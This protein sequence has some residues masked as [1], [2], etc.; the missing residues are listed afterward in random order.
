MGQMYFGNL[1]RMQMVTAALSE[2]PVSSKGYSE[3]LNYANGGADV[4]SSFGSSRTFDMSWSGTP[5]EVNPFK[6]YQQGYY[7]PGLLYM[8]DPMTEHYNVCPPNWA[9]PRLIEVGD[10]KNIYDTTPTFAATSANSYNQPARK[11]TW[12]ITTAAAG[13]PAHVLTLPIPPDRVL[14]IGAS[15]AATGTA[16]VRVRP[17]NL[18]GTYAA[19]SDLTLLSDTGSARLNKT[20][21]GA[22]YKAVQVYFT[23][24]TSVTSTLTVTSLMAQLWPIGTTPALIGEHIPGE[25]FGGLKFASGVS[26]SYYQAAGA[27]YERK[28]ASAQLVE[29]ESW[30]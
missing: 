22:T 18:N 16:V 20:F 30:Q 7:G 19:T 15:A 25:G 6:H 13:V 9:S 23:R 3:V 29:V 10:W 24:T 27:G 14:H 28:G 21:S 5:S 2:L 26:E 17:I 11:A 12:S 4:V 8:V 1:E